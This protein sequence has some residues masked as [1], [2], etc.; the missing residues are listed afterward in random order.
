MIIKVQEWE[1]RT[2]HEVKPAGDA[3]INLGSTWTDNALHACCLYLAEL[4]AVH[5]MPDFPYSSEN[6]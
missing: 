3:P 5:L 4:R 6:M 1:E 2:Y